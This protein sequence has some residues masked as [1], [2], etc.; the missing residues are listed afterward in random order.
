[1]RRAL[2]LAAS[3][4]ALLAAAAPAASARPLTLG[5][6]D[7]VFDDAAS[8]RDPW[9]DRAA[10]TGAQIVR[11]D[12]GW[13]AATR[14]QQPADPAD[15]AYDFSA[16]DDRVRAARA[17]GL[18]VLL[19]FTGAP[20]WA[21]GANRPSSA[22]TGS[23]RPDPAAVGAYGE[24]LARRYSGSY[25]GLPRVRF[26]QV[27]NEPNLSKY[28]APQWVR[29]DGRYVAE[30]PVRYRAMLNAFY[31]GVKR[32][33][34]R[35]TVVTAGTAPFGDPPGGSRIA[36]V[37]FVRDLLCLRGGALATAPCADP[38]HFDALSH[39]PYS[40]GPP[41]RG[42]LNPDDVSIPDFGKLS[43]ILRRA[44]RTGRALPRR[45]KALW[46]TEVSF[47]SSP[48]DPDG[49]PLPTHARW[50]AQTFELLW[51][52]GVTTITWFNVRDQPPRP[53]Y[54]ATNQSGVFF[55]DGR[56]KPAAAAFRFPFVVRRPRGA[57]IVWARAPVAGTL[58][59]ERR[60][61]GRWSPLLAVRVGAGQVV[62]RRLHGHPHSLRARIGSQ[63]SILWR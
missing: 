63:R 55:L 60:A 29:R 43:R 42:A 14:P 34:P 59:V 1:M 48:P 49:V 23:W 4:T 33:Q 40:I 25:A 57:T 5:F 15:P 35:A 8:V 38:A 31:A 21:E 19:G 18:Q 61:G 16:V 13:P 11:L 7:S 6:A 53:S 37:V 24:A 54:A 41:G 2:A 62:Q 12:A 46:S 32:A 27:W 17:Q 26:F 51:R 20:R 3:I 10:A 30:A 52:Q 9:F 28:L 36:P 22:E 56:A 44:V 39:H 45:T 58:V 50:L 47:D